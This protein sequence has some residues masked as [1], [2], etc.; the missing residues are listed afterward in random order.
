MI[1][2]SL[3]GH[4][5]IFV[6]LFDPRIKAVVSSCGFNSFRDYYDGKIAGW[7]HKGYMPRL[8]EVYDL[9]LARVPFD[10]PEL[11]GAAGTSGILHE[12]SRTTPASRS[13]VVACI[14]AARPV[15]ELWAWATGWSRSIPMP[16]MI[17]RRNNETR[18]RLPRPP[19]RNPRGKAREEPSG[20]TTVEIPVG[21]Q[22]LGG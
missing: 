21:Y 4:N 10:F 19:V 13:G 2:H 12:L 18:V 20:L 11:I 1:G 6:A 22:W 16:G 15:Y 3:G 14:D 9:D 8:R 7:S 5:S 17:S